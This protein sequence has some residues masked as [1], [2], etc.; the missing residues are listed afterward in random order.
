MENCLLGG[1]IMT[2]LVECNYCKNKQEMKVR[3]I[4]QVSHGK[5]MTMYQFQC[6]KCG[7]NFWK[8]EKN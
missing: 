4:G 7:K 5:P 3:E 2:K 1:I 8:H 6:P